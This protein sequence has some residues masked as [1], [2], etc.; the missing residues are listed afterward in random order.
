MSCKEKSGFPIGKNSDGSF[1]VNMDNNIVRVETEK[2]AKWLSMLPV[3]L[4]N[5][6]TNTP[7]SPNIENIKEI[8][9]VCGEYNINSFAVRKLKNWLKNN[10]DQ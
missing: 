7:E 4:N 10:I 9:T 6:F 5:I 8:I 1:S 3:E 2:D